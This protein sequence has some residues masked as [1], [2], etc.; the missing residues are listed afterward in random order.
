MKNLDDKD[1]SI[2]SVLSRNANIPLKTLAAEIGLSRSATS[3]RVL[4][5][6]QTG[7]I[8]G[9]RAVIEEIG[10]GGISAFLLIVLV[11]NASQKVFEQLASYSDIKRVSS[12][13]GQIDLIVEIEVDAVHRLNSIRN[14]VEAFA[15]V[16]D[17][18]T[19][20]VM[21]RDIDKSSD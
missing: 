5:L 9:Y 3:E 18:T 2:L 13:S 11:R 14:E 15:D 10:E 8:R 1:R 6:E 17:V 16:Q 21:R 19:S 7:V 12:V 4:S 20:I